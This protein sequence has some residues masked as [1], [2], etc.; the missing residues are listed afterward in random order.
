MKQKTLINRKLGVLSDVNLK[1]VSDYLDKLTAYQEA[2][3]SFVQAS[4]QVA[5][6][7]LEVDGK[8]YKC[9]FCKKERDKVRRL[10][11]GPDNV[12]ICD[13]CVKLCQEI[14]EDSLKS[15]KT[16]HEQN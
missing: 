2:M 1:R 4:E 7:E 14:I 6:L 16:D 15:E 10:V 11:L 3:D 5:A 9:S 8:N 12:C 13:G